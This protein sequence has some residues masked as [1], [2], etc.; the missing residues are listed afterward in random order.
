MDGVK[1]GGMGK[2]GSSGER[3]EEMREGWGKEGGMEERREEW[4]KVIFSLEC[5]QIYKR[6]L[7]DSV[8]VQ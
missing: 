7:S 3:R 5:S 1:E 6:S 8:P 4:V 2:G